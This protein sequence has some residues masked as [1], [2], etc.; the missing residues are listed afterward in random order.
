MLEYRGGR[1]HHHRDISLVN[2]STK[3]FGYNHRE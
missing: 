3:A 1:E 2:K